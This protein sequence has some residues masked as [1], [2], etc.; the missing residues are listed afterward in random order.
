M[1]EP[2]FTDPSA[3]PT[4]ARITAALGR[5][6]SAWRVLFDAL[7]DRAPDLTGT[8]G[9]YADGRSW[10][11][12]LARRQKTVCWVAVEK[13]RFHVA[14]YFAERLVP[15]LLESALP[16]ARKEAIRATAP[17]GKLRPV[18][19]TFGPQRGVRDVLA[20]VELKRTLK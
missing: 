3:A 12:K 2:F 15:A 20:L 1:S 6:A 11:L 14:F 13:G 4:D 16:D 18:S 9:Y 17:H 7:R 8:W 19:I 5:A 10:L